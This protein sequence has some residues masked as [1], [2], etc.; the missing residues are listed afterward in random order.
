MK[1]KLVKRTERGWAGHYCCAMECQFRRNTLLEKGEV[2]IVV[3]TVGAMFQRNEEDGYSEI[4]VNRYYETMVFFAK[5][6]QGIYL[7]VDVQK[8]IPI[9]QN[10]QIGKISEKADLEANNMHESIVKEMIERIQKGEFNAKSSNEKGVS[11]ESGQGSKKRKTQRH[12]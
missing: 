5:L 2:K 9:N 7:D 11:K 6:E 3:S 8:Q 4:G 1:V 12:I 10:W